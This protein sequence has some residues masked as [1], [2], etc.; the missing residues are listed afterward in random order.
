VSVPESAGI[1]MS[2]SEPEEAAAIIADEYTEIGVQAPAGRPFAMNL[3][4]FALP[5]MRY[6]ELSFSESRVRTRTYP[7][8]TLCV[9][10]AGSLIA[11]ADDTDDV[12]YGTDGAVVSPGSRVDARYLSDGIVIRTVHFEIGLALSELSAL[13]GRSVVTPPRFNF[14]RPE[15]AGAAAIRR[16]VAVLSDELRSGSPLMAE[17]VL[18]ERL[19]RLV[20]SSL[21]L[22]H[23]HSYSAELQGR[24]RVEGPRAIRTLL[25]R[26]DAAPLE[27]ATVGDLAAAA[28]LSVRALQDGV[29]RHVGTSPMTYLRQARLQKVHEALVQAD[30]TTATATAIARAWG[31]AHYGRFAAD[32]RARFGVSPTRSLRA[33]PRGDPR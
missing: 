23:P 30:P 19:G 14:A 32:Y 28:G 2:A 10:T 12:V 6:G 18:A 1:T 9:P 17:P 22:G 15:G 20:L 13:L 26:I 8:Y 27:F 5:N 4:A 29:A 3:Q 7:S 33:G 16:A 25:G 24:S 31:F 11:T 21:L